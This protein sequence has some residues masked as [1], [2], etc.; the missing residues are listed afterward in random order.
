ME[1]GSEREI[2]FSFLF[3]LYFN[4]DHFNQWEEMYNENPIMQKVVKC[5]FFLLAY[6]FWQSKKSRQR[7]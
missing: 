1:E 4:F 5:V 2:N 3:S 7:R 6:F